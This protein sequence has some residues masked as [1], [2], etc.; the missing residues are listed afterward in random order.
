MGS[1]SANPLVLFLNNLYNRKYDLLS[2]AVFSAYHSFSQ[3]GLF[4]CIIRPQNTNKFS[5][6]K[7]ISE[8]SLGRY[9]RI[10]GGIKPIWFSCIPSAQL[11]TSSG[12]NLKRSVKYEAVENARP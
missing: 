6:G 7:V 1:I 5:A 2:K 8:L 4:H 11:T 3:A 9:Y 12:L 10:V